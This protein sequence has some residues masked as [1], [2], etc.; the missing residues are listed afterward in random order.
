MSLCVF[1]DNNFL[2]GSFWKQCENLLTTTFKLD[3]DKNII[4]NVKKSFSTNKSLNQSFCEK[5]SKQNFIRFL[6]E[7]KWKIFSIFLNGKLTMEW[8]IRTVNVDTDWFSRGKIFPEKNQEKK[9][10]RKFPKKKDSIVKSSILIFSEV[11]YAKLGRNNKNTKNSFHFK[12]IFFLFCLTEN[13]ITSSSSMDFRFVC[14]TH[15]PKENDNNW[16][17]QQQQKIEKNW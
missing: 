5:S 9:I 6:W 15:I 17:P 16:C 14:D 11:I 10:R 8:F 4:N 2:S 7:K 12:T 1:Q 3:K 13:L